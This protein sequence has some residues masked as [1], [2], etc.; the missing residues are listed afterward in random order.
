MIT[1]I[2]DLEGYDNLLKSEKPLM[3]SFKAT[4]CAPCKALQPILEEFALNN[5]WAEVATVDVDTNFD[6]ASKF[7]ILKLPT[8]LLFKDGEVFGDR[9]YGVITKNEISNQLK[10]LL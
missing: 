6:L 5:T 3:V 8:T 2:K 4:W 9:I 1:V 7:D 10:S